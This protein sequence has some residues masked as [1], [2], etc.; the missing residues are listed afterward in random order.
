MSDLAAGVHHA[1]NI[2]A[3]SRARMIQ[4]MW[5]LVMRMFSEPR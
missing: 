2:L 1:R 3:Q 5:A 4:A